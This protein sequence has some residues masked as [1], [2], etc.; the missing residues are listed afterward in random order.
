MDE[1][2]IGVFKHFEIQLFPICLNDVEISNR[3]VEMIKFIKIFILDFFL[4]E[5]CTRVNNFGQYMLIYFLWNLL[6]L[7]NIQ[8]LNTI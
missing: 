8:I 2:E 3:T 5:F 1:M 4:A 7:E 6:K